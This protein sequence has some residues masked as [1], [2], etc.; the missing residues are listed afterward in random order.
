MVGGKQVL[1]VPLLSLGPLFYCV[2]Y[3]IIIRQCIYVMTS[4]QA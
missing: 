2:L 4:K 1:L 3:Y